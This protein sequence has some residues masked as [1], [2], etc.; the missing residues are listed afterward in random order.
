VHAM[1]R[2]VHAWER[3]V[4]ARARGIK[5][6]TMSDIVEIPVPV[7][8]WRL[9]KRGNLWLDVGDFLATVLLRREGIWQGRVLRKGPE[10][11]PFV[12]ERRSGGIVPCVDGSELARLFF[13]FCRLVGAAMCSACLCGS[14]DRWP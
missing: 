4:H 14:H 6:E 3:G 12:G 10:G 7:T 13:T 11:S 2:G 8:L 1:E 9:S 5:E